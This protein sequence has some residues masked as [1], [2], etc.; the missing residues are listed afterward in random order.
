MNVNLQAWDNFL[1]RSLIIFLMI[2]GVK[3]FPGIAR[4]SAGST[5]FKLLENVAMNALFAVLV[6]RTGTDIFIGEGPWPMVLSV[7][8]GTF[9]TAGLHRL[10]M[11]FERRSPND[12]AWEAKHL[13]NAV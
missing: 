1:G 4:A 12:P 3:T 13:R 2:E 6:Q 8:F 7:V 9:A 5:A 11:A 10:K